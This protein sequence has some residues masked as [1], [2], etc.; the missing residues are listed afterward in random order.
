MRRIVINGREYTA[1]PFDFNMICDLED[2]GVSIEDIERKPVSIV[3]AYAGI[4]MGKSAKESGIE[5]QEHLLNGGS[6]DDIMKVISKEMEES[7][8]FRNLGENKEKKATT[9]PGKKGQKNYHQNNRHNG[10]RNT[11]HTGNIT[12]MNGSRKR[13]DWE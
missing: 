6:F 5:I 9:H 1:K 2:L 12:P 3:R 8:F 11:G 13:D 4:C 10:N 7:D